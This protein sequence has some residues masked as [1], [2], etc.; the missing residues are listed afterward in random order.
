MG[1][2]AVPTKECWGR[3]GPGPDTNQHTRELDL[4]TYSVELQYLLFSQEMRVVIGD[5]LSSARPWNSPAL[6]ATGGSGQLRLVQAAAP[7]GAPKNR[8]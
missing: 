2:L 6:T 7:R 5:R 8:V 4:W 1:S 3:G